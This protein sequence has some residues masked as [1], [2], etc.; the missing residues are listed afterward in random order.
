VYRA[1]ITKAS[2]GELD[3]TPLLRRLLALR[4]EKATLLGFAR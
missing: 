3:N 2:S 4:R 1:S